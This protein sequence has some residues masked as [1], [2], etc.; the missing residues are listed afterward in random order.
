MT[1]SWLLLYVL[2]IFLRKYG[3]FLTAKAQIIALSMLVDSSK[4][5]YEGQKN[6][7]T[8]TTGARSSRVETLF[9]HVYFTGIPHTLQ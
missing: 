8:L 5:L 9:F 6:K 7:Q 3:Y 2:V 4:T 1:Y